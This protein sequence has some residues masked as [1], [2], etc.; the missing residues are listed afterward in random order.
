MDQLL[1]LWTLS[2]TLLGWTIDQMRQLVRPLEWGEG[3]VIFSLLCIW[4][5]RVLHWFNVQPPR[6]ML[7]WMAGGM[8]VFMLVL[9]PVILAPRIFYL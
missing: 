5:I 8:K 9:K 7:T 1:E 2:Q 3:M 6:P 4:Y